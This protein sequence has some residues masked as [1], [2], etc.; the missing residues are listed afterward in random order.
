[1]TT[2]FD[3][4]KKTYL[5]LGYMEISTATGG[6][7]GY[8][9]DTNIGPDNYGDDDI[10]GN[11]VFIIKAGGTAPEGEVARVSAYSSSTNTITF[12][13]SLT[14]AVDRGDK[15]GLVRNIIELETLKELVN[16]A[17][18]SMGT[19]QLADTSLVTVA[20]QSEYTIPTA[21]KYKINGVQMQTDKTN[22]DWNDIGG[23]YVINSAA[24]STG[25]LCFSNELPS[26][27]SLKLL[28]ETE[29]PDVDLLSDEIS[30][31][32]HSDYIVK[33]VVEKALEYQLRRT[34]GTNEFL[35]QTSN[36]AMEDSR[37]AMRRYTQPK[38][39]K[40]KYLTP[41]KN[42]ATDAES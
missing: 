22:N 15:Y 28:Y 32:F 42:E 27:Y 24:G 21:L 5:S 34:G 20:S 35:R 11:L 9:V 36:K 39:K 26:G 40:P 23:W 16:D 29:H 13:S 7:R 1:M 8:L 4:L 12:S 38:R 31:V 3:I 19:I 37:E 10:V 33:V 2:L 30:E 17:L 14:V 41:Y 6:S 25:L 18:Q